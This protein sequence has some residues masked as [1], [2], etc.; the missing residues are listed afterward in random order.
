MAM[1]HV[2]SGKLEANKL[3]ANKVFVYAREG[4]QQALGGSLSLKQA[5]K[6]QCLVRCAVRQSCP[7]PLPLAGVLGKQGHREVIKA[8]QQRNEKRDNLVAS[9]FALLFAAL[10]IGR[11]K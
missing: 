3:K 2:A 10:S 7:A 1:R 4:G 11:V 5:L 9:M 8:K 6:W